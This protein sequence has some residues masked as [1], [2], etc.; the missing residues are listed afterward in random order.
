MAACIHRLLPRLTFALAVTTAAT[1]IAAEPSETVTIYRCTSEDGQLTLRDSPC[2]AGARQQIIQMQRPQDPPPQPPAPPAPPTPP[3]PAPTA[4]PPTR[5]VVI[6]RTPLYQCIT[7]DGVRYTSDSPTGNPRWVPLWTL[8]YPARY[9]LPHPLP[10]RVVQRNRDN[11]HLFNGLVFDGIGR[12]TPT[13]TDT[14]PG[15]PRV[16]PA[17]GLARTPGTW[18]RDR[19]TRIPPVVACERLRERWWQLRRDRNSALQSERE[20]IDAEQ[21]AIQ[22]RLARDC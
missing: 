17:V 7:P 12:P 9:S 16:P 19:C 22:V 2:R 4:P 21:E 8:G 13:P 5:V 6:E 3:Q 18:I 10:P 20:R 11:S 1:A 15:A 14:T